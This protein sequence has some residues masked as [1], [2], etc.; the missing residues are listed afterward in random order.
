MTLNLEAN[1]NIK[2]RSKQFN[3]RTKEH[4]L[5]NLESIYIKN[6]SFNLNS[7][8]LKFRGDFMTLN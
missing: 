6:Q 3:L 2:F 4:V 5:S 8:C 1:F 7:S